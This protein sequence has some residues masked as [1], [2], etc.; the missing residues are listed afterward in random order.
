[1]FVEFHARSAF[2]FLQGA[3]QPEE[4]VEVAASYDQPGIAVLDRDGVYGSVRQHLA[5]T[6]LCIRAHIGAEITCADGTIYPLLC[7]TQQGYRNLCTLTTRLKMRAAKGEGAATREEIAEHADGLVCLGG[8][9]GAPSLET[10]LLIFGKDRVYAELQ[11]H[12]R[13]EQE[14]RNQHTIELAGRMK[15]PLLATC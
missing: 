8:A 15:I 9:D 13:R 6:K 1:V 7:E 4:L 14:A 10:A 2:T 11:R 12:M 5:A 3:S